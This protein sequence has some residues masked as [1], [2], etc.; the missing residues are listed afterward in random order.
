MVGEAD[1]LE[2]VQA[3]LREPGFDEVI[4]STLPKRISEWLWRDL[5]HRIQRPGGPVTT[6]HKTRRKSRVALGVP[7]IGLTPLCSG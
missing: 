6:S 5:P 3:A 7:P 2:A 1:P 4:V